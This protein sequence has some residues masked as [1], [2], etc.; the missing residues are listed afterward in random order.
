M[1]HGP[2]LQHVHQ[3][4]I[5]LSAKKESRLKDHYEMLMIIIAFLVPVA[6][7]PQMYKIWYF[8]DASGISI[9]SWSSFIIFSFFWL[10][11]GIIHKEKPLIIMYIFLII[12][13]SIILAGGF[14]YAS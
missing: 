7:I 4:K 12:I 9:I 2:A 1:A 13:Q 3:K 6:H 14:L 8:K 5:K 10:F 11:Y